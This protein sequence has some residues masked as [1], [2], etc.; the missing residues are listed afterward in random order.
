M[1]IKIT[2]C[3]DESYLAS[4]PALPG[5]AVRGKTQDEAQE[6]IKDAIAGYLTSLNVAL[7]R[8]LNRKFHAEMQPA[9]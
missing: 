1:V 4:C 5:C 7:P 9:A 8:E 3:V 2:R 6:R